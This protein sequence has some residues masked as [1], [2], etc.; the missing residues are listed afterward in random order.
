MWNLAG[1]TFNSRLLLGTARYPSFQCLADAIRASGTEIITISLRRQSQ[2][3]EASMGFWDTVKQLNCHL[4]PNTAECTSAKD[5]IITAQMA[6][7]V[8]NTHW[9]KLEV[10]YD[11]YTLQPD[12]FELVIAAKEL[13]S[14]GFEVFPYSTDDLVV[15]ERLVHLG[16][17]I[18]MPW[19]APIGSG[20]GI[21]HP[22]ALHTL[23]ERLKD[24]TLI[25]DAGIGASSH[26]AKAM[27]LG[28]DGVLLNNAVALAADPV[29]MASAFSK[30]VEAGH[31]AYHAG[32]I[33][34]QEFAR[35]STPLLGRPFWHQENIHA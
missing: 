23:R 31:L 30:A 9:I 8:F 33:P 22:E 28:M 11:D 3:P 6:R 2:K 24:I 15:C 25:V 18:V 7:E 27:E 16:C 14:Q 35:P 13:I 34:P 20:K 5:A 12:P 17:R 19:A 32:I 26:A 29:K 21:I 4:L 10:I 1:K